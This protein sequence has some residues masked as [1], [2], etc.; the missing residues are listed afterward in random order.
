VASPPG[1]LEL[2]LSSLL[3]HVED[4]LAHA[5]GKPFPVRALRLASTAQIDFP[6]PGAP[7]EDPGIDPLDN[8]ESPAEDVASLAVCRSLVAVMGGQLRIAAH[9]E[10]GSRLE[11]ELPLAQRGLLDQ[12][13]EHQFNA[14]PG[15][16]LTALIVEPDPAACRSLVTALGE[17]GHRAVPAA[18]AD[19]AI[20]L[21]KRV[22]FHVFFCSASAPGTPWQD[23]LQDTRNRIRTFVLLTQGHDPALQAA[24]ARNNTLALALPLRRQDLAAVLNA[25]ESRAES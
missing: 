21:A 8:P 9:W 14:R 7:G 2:V 24:L 4:R 20:D 18:T 1:V 12:A 3:R 10:S 23:C 5:G 17:L 11:A 13:D 25:V 22:D 6:W 16:P 19:E 15:A